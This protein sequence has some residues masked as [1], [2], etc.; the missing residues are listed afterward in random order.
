MRRPSLRL[1]IGSVALS[2][3]IAVPLATFTE[4]FMTPIAEHA[5]V[6]AS[7]GRWQ[8]QRLDNEGI[9]R[10]YYS[11]LDSTYYNPVYIA[12][13]GLREWEVLSGKGEFDF[14]LRYYQTL[15]P[16]AGGD[17]ASHAAH[18]IALADW[19]ASHLVTRE[20]DGVSFGVWPYSFPWGLYGLPAGWVS[21]MAQGVGIQ[22]LVRAWH[23]T[24][25]VRY[26]RAAIAASR[27]F[28]VEVADG[29]VTYKDGPADWW[30]EEYASP[31]AVQPRV[32]NGMEHAIL[33]LQDLVTLGDYPE[34]QG[35][36]TRGVTSL[37]RAIAAFDLG[38]WTSY[39]RVGTIA[40]HKYQLVNVA[41]TKA[42]AERTRSPVLRRAADRWAKYD[43][44]FFQREFLRQRPNY[45]DVAILALNAAFV[46]VVIA[47]VYGMFSARRAQPAT[48]KA[49][50]KLPRHE[51]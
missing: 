15:A 34:A 22:V 28:E 25:D 4:P 42:L 49:R 43:A 33:G 1:L 18:F 36:V 27:A 5:M 38:W 45:V 23:L 26:R 9:P 39:D 19:L 31:G 50:A 12:M 20:S 47:A 29:G 24:G 8:V 10:Q 30:Y 32:L 46:W 21:G 11:R 7:S 35:L 16:S 48:R 13:L 2:C 17:S 44:E 6:L 41:L 40:N 51:R 3:I 37:E 14:F